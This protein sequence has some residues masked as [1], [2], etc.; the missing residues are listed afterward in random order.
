M[1][2]NRLHVTGDTMLTDKRYAAGAICFPQKQE[3]STV[4]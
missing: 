4:Q 3:I 1:V 2:F